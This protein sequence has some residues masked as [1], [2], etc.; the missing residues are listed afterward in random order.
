MN[1][2]TPQKTILIVEDEYLVAIDIS[3]TLNAHGF[4]AITVRDAQEGHDY[5]L[6]GTCDAVVLDHGLDSDASEVLADLLKANGIPFAFCTGVIASDIS[7]RHRDV[8][9]IEKPF[10]P[11][12]LIEVTQGLLE[13]A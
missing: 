3:E 7:S 11:E 9:V 4:R 6:N 1:A 5:V 8:P 2:I 13:R 10:Q 12:R